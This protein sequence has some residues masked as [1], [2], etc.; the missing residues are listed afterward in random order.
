MSRHPILLVAP[1][2]SVL[3]L[4]GC[5][6]SPDIEAAATEP[7]TVVVTDANDFA[8]LENQTFNNESH[9]HDYWGGADR[10][11]VTDQTVEDST[12]F[13][14]DD[15]ESL[16]E[17]LR[18]EVV[19]QGTAQLEMTLSWTGAS[20]DTHT[21]PELWVRGPAD[22]EPFK[23]ATLAQ[24]ETLSIDLDEADADLPHQ[25]LS[26]WR[27]AFV[28][29]PDNN[30]ELIVFDGS[31]TLHVEAVRG[32]DIPL[33]PPHGDLWDGAEIMALLSDGDGLG[34][35][36]GDSTA[37]RANC[38]GACPIVHRPEDG[39]IVPYDA[40]AVEA[41]LIMDPTN[42]TRLGLAYHGADTREWTR[43]DPVSTSNGAWRYV[44]PL[45]TPQMGDGPY[46]SQSQ[47]EFLPFIDGPEEDGFYAGD[48]TLDVWV[49]KFAPAP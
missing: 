14:S 38:Y 26:R 24:G 9:L 4:A 22:A 1:L 40:A 33:Y 34:A 16:I 42:P 37:D 36:E 23:V 10:L 28:L 25:S 15:W 5:A 3:M 13:F 39:A 44:I 2:L 47:W 49:H 20:T 45:E 11:V 30:G 41:I 32:L 27:F 48:Y 46:A 29:H 8:S 12:F 31:I 6:D 18:G 19:P 35:W 17:P 7:D 21:D 43:L